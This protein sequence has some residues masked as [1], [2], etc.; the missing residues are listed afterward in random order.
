[1]GSPG[2]R[3]HARS[4]D[5]RNRSCGI[6]RMIWT[7][8]RHCQ[9]GIHADRRS[10]PARS[11]SSRSDS[12]R[13]RGRAPRRAGTSAPD[14]RGSRGPARQPRP[15]GIAASAPSAR[16]RRVRTGTVAFVPGIVRV[17]PIRTHEIA[18]SARDRRVR[19][20]FAPVRTPQPRASPRELRTGPAPRYRTTGAP[21]PLTP[22]R[23]ARTG[24]AT[25]APSARGR[26]VRTEF[27]HPHGVA[28]FARDPIP[29]EHDDP[30][31]TPRAFGRSPRPP[32]HGRS[33][34]RRLRRP[35]RLPRECRV[36]AARVPGTPAPGAVDRIR[37][38]GSAVAS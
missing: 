25:T 23:S 38:A 1:M 12:W 34:L 6:A 8:Q 15:H 21:P 18:A 7:H 14:R 24:T 13:S 2:T 32:P 22:D 35:P 28:V 30:V 26:R 31:R 10:A 9:G 19:T 16:V 36:G 33:P 4:T 11:C 29:C 27:P 37:R 20:R 5:R 3:R 17:D